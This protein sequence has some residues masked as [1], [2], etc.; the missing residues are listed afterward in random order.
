MKYLSLI[1]LS[2]CS[3][4]LSPEALPIEEAIVEE[5]VKEVEKT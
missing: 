2:S 4:L 5:I 3:L 1:F